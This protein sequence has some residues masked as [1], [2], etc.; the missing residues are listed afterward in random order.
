MED[1]Y[2]YVPCPTSTLL[3]DVTRRVELHVEVANW[4]EKQNPVHNQTFTFG[5]IRSAIDT[6]C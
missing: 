5:S 1:F 4:W 6:Q 2:D 3:V